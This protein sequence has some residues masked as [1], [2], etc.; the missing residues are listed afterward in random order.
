MYTKTRSEGFGDEVIR[1]IMIGTY[2]LSSGY[3]DA[4][5]LKA[6]KVRTLVRQ[7]FE[8]CFQNVDVIAAPV[9]PTPP[10]KIGENIH[11]PLAMY[12]G[13]VFTV[14]I[15]LAGVA[16]ISLPCGFTAGGL[17]IGLQLISGHFKEEQLLRTAF[18]FQEKT[19]FHKMQPDVVKQKILAE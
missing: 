2:A 12:L 19:D 11:D 9:T 6:Q 18:A 7:D 5:Y 17:P 3:Y 15:N 4:Y 13:D 10:F 16:G 14:P 1:R 8:R